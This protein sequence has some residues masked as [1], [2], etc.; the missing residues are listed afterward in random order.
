[1]NRK[2]AGIVIEMKEGIIME[3]GIYFYGE[4][5]SF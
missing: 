1:M 5:I 4:L 3:C 2:V